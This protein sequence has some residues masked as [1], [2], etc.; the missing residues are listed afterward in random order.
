MVNLAVSGDM[1]KDRNQQ[2]KRL[3]PILADVNIFTRGAEKS[4]T[5]I[6]EEKLR[7]GPHG[8]KAGRIVEV[9]INARLQIRFTDVY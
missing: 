9:E 5:R 4:R 3:F 7:A 2:R 8:L 1:L 6:K